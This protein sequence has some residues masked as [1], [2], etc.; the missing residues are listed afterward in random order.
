MH[1]AIWN[2]VQTGLGSK[3]GMP[4]RA[5]RFAHAQFLRGE[6]KSRA[7]S[8]LRSAGLRRWL[9]FEQRVAT[10]GR[11]VSDALKVAPGPPVI[12]SGRCSNKKPEPRSAGCRHGEQRLGVA[13]ARR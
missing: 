7:R 8:H 11:Q 4:R 1:R 6:E 12:A 5:I 9:A 3:K 2:H 10:R 13:H